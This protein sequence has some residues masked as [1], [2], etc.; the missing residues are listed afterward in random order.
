MIAKIVVTPTKEIENWIVY[1]SPSKKVDVCLKNLEQLC[2]LQNLLEDGI[3][4]LDEFTQQK[5]IVL[6]E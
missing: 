5:R 3:L 1:F 4:S 2:I 6:Q